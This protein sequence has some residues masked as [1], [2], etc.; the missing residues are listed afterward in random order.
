M[1]NV[2]RVLD[3]GTGSGCIAIAIAY[4]FGVEVD[5]VDISE[6]ALTVAK[7]NIAQHHL[8]HQVH[9]VHSDLFSNL[10]GLHY[11]LIVANPPYVD[12]HEIEI[13]PSEYHHEPL[14]ALEAGKD[15]L[16]FVK[17]ILRDAINHLT[18]KGILIVEVGASEPAVIAQYP[19]VPFT[20]L[21]FERG[22]DGIFLLSAEQVQ[23]YH[24]IFKEVASH[25][26][27]TL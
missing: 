25:Q 10:S 3:L 6:E 19:D 2:N 17:Q 11:D 21:E 15:G 8:E 4:H 9:A 1:N 22:G 5:A 14:S 7:K 20:W 13:M 12:A 27:G 16:Y 26:L 23:Q 18:P 24:A